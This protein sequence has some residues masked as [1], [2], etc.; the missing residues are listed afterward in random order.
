[1]VKYWKSK[2]KVLFRIKKI[3]FI[4]HPIFKNNVYNLEAEKTTSRSY[5]T[6]IIGSNGTGKSILLKEICDILIAI[7]A[8]IE[9][10]RNDLSVDFDFI[11]HYEFNGV[12][13]MVSKENSKTMTYENIDSINVLPSQILAISY[14]LN[15]KYPLL[16]KKNKNYIE[17]YRYLGIRSTTNNAFITKHRKDF[18]DNIYQIFKNINKQEALQEFFTEMKLPTRYNLIVSAG[19]NYN[20]LFSETITVDNILSVT[21]KIIKG[22]INKSKRFSDTKFEQLLKDESLQ[23]IILDFFNKN[24]LNK[25]SIKKAKKYLEYDINI[26]DDLNND[27]V[28]DYIAIEILISMEVL[29]L[30]E[31]EIIKSDSY[32]YNNSSSGEFHI[33]NSITSI[34][35]YIDN[36]SLIF[37]DEPEISLHPNWQI[38]YIEILNKIIHKYDGC[39]I[40]IATHSHFIISSLDKGSSTVI[41]AK[42]DSFNNI[43]IQ[44]IEEDTY[45]WSAENI[46]YNVFGIATTRN[47]YFER[48]LKSLVELIATKQGSYEEAKNILDKFK[49]FNIKQN[50]PLNEIIRMGNKYLDDLRDNV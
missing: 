48:D 41:S 30:E 35:A 38:K 21:E 39:H 29:K 45:G 9:K 47:S 4:N 23:R 46:L 31:L 18:I 20:K 37:M 19:T 2:R 34:I 25:E 32:A 49:S 12:S 27:F 10:E 11:L 22:N 5:K 28:E 43:V 44:N 7:K 6:V 3:T 15:D 36:N 13:Y 1:M 50:D 26:D 14:N 16:T 42:K 40:I 8:N 33:I 24:L 17:S